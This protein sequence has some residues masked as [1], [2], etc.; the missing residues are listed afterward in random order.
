MKAGEGLGRGWFGRGANKTL[1]IRLVKSLYDQFL[2][3]KIFVILCNVC[4][5]KQNFALAFLF[6]E[7]K[8]NSVVI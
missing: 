6:L 8:K 4:Q 1:E 2:N 5:L 7:K 3:T